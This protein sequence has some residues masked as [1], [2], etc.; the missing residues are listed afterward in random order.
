MAPGTNLV[1][2]YY[3]GTTGGNTGGTL[4]VGNANNY[5]N[6]GLTGSS[7]A[8]PIVAS[9][10]SVL[11]SAAYQAGLSADARDAMV[12]K[13]VLMNSADKTAGW[14]NGQVSNV[15]GGVN[16]AQALDYSAGTGRLDMA[17]AYGQFLTGSLDPHLQPP[18]LSNL[19]ANIGNVQPNGWD[20][21]TVQHGTPNEYFLSGAETAGSMLTVTL[22]WFRDRT[23]TIAGS[24]S[25]ASLTANPQ[26]LGQSRTQSVRVQL[27]N[28]PD[29][30]HDHIG[31]H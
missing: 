8:A 4:Q 24:D 7:F 10:V 23:T 29:R 30:R 2:T 3:D 27:H 22:D 18:S 15:N 31:L 5:Y 17:R 19:T 14:N 11:D 13:A 1:S 20:L 12:I 21:G 28:R 6:S 9:A 26:D 25:N 16:T